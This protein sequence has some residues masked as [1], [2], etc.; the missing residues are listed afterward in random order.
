MPKLMGQASGHSWRARLIL[1]VALGFEKRTPERAVSSN[2][3]IDAH[4]P[5]TPSVTGFRRT[6]KSQGLANAARV[7]AAGGG[8]APLYRAGIGLLVAESS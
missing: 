7:H 4:S 5:A 8:V 3:V 1:F 2:P 6:G